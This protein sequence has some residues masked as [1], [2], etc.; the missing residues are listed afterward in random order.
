V[1][2]R[3][4]L[5]AGVSKKLAAAT[6]P[7]LAEIDLIRP[8]LVQEFLPGKTLASLITS[9]MGCRAPLYSWSDALR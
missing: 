2:Y 9:Q 3:G 5:S 8:S 7:C 1:G 6:P 4:M